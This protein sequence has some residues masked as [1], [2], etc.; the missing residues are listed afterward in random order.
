MARPG[1]LTALAD[2]RLTGPGPRPTLPAPLPR[3]PARL[4]AQ[5]NRDAPPERRWA[6]EGT[7]AFGP[8]L[9]VHG[10][11]LANGLRLWALPDPAAP[12]V[13]YHTWYG[14]GSADERPGK[15]GLAHFFEHLMFNETRSLPQGEFDRLMEEAGGET[16]A[17]TWLDWTYYYESLPSEELPLAVRLEAERMRGLVL[18]PAQV[19]S[20]REVVA[21][22]RRMAV[23][24]DVHGTA[25]ERLYTALFG[26]EHPYGW[27]TIG[28]MED[29]RGYRLEDCR[30]FYDR[31]YAPD[32]ATVVVVGAFDE[33]ALLRAM[34][35]A[36]GS[37][38]PAGGRAA[39]PPWD[40]PP[41]GRARPIDLHWPTPT[42][43]ALF[44]WRAPAYAAPEH[45]AVMVIDE[46]L[47]G[48]RS[49]RLRRRLVEELELV[50]EVH[51]G[52]A[53]LRE[54]G[55]FEL[56]VSAREGVA[57]D[58]IERVLAEELDRIMREPVD[59]DEIEKVRNRSELL[60]LSEIETVGGKAYQVGFGD[61]VVGDPGHAWRRLDELRAVDAEDVQR[62]A[63]ATFGSAGPTG[64]AAVR[65]RTVE[66]HA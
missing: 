24:D 52:V 48:G 7:V 39:L 57:L 50:S 56:W 9:S 64:E 10:W 21:N 30:A 25:M 49:S 19:E 13:S 54:A 23:D 44:G 16:N 18:R 66:A 45:A 34:Q 55:V 58:E 15:T 4:E 1:L 14:V 12:V 53:P 28:W 62:A 26:R 41:R 60:F 47:S 40:E 17:A 63:A 65:V 5:V 43:K 32:N 38:R 11:R 35:E 8:R 46:I 37:F 33:E 20:E 27:P 59:R 42:E 22:E 2:E 31:W 29:I 61:R 51:T 6:S 3:S 36:Y